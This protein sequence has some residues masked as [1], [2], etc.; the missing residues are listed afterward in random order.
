MLN[1][2]LLEHQVKSNIWQHLSFT[3]TMHQSIIIH[4]YYS[5]YMLVRCNWLRQNFGE[6]MIWRIIR[7]FFRMFSYQSLYTPFVCFPSLRN[8][9]QV[10]IMLSSD[11]SFCN[12]KS[13][14]LFRCQVNF[15]TLCCRLFCSPLRQLL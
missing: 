5:E 9:L 13:I 1:N 11:S 8:S 6:L 2:L 12:R 3:V 4:T 14:L 7:I 10:F 15:R